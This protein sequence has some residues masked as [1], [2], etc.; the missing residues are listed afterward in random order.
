MCATACDLAC[1]H[2]AAYWNAPGV[3]R[4]ST[5]NMNE[6]QLKDLPFTAPRSDKQIE[7]DIQRR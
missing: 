1:G 5:K 7:K 3:L 6:P 2:P 4:A